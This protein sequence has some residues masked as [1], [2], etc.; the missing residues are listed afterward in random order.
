MGHCGQ[1]MVHHGREV[2]RLVLPQW[3]PCDRI[4]TEQSAR[5]LGCHDL[6]SSERLRHELYGQTDVQDG[7]EVLIVTT[8]SVSC[9]RFLFLRR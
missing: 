1:M 3:K 9:R 2:G 5:Y 6:L 4:T 7:I 8:E